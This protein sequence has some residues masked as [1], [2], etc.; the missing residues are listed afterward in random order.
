MSTNSNKKTRNLIAS[1]G[2]VSGLGL[3]PVA[4]ILLAIFIGRQLDTFLKTSPILLLG[5]ILITIPLSLYLMVRAALYM[6][7]IDG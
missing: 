3:I 5:L 2:R 1:V 4:C 7:R 6:T